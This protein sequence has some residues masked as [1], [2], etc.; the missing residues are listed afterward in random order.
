MTDWRLPVRLGYATTQDGWTTLRVK[1]KDLSVEKHVR[2]RCRFGFD[3]R[4]FDLPFISHC[5][6]Y[7]VFADVVPC[8]DEFA[9]SCSL[10]EI[11]YWDNNDHKNY[12]VPVWKNAI[13][14]KVSLRTARMR[15]LD[16]D[17]RWMQGVV[18]VENLSS[19]KNVGVSLLPDGATQWVDLLGTYDGVAGEGGGGPWVTGPV[20]RWRFVSPIFRSNDFRF[21][22]FYRDQD[23]GEIYW[24]NNFGQDYRFEGGTDLD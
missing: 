18:Y 7:D 24:D 4:D 12:R 11:E 5:Y 22:V 2:V 10:D 9:V 1:V 3:W 20:E 17:H 16:A 23:S 19:R 8:A 6:G 15:A 14:G 13:G 21:A